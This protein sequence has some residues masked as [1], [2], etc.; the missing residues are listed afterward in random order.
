MARKETGRGSL[1]IFARPD[2]KGR[3]THIART[4]LRRCHTDSHIE[5]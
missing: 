1:G 3:Q 5:V 2:T 4:E